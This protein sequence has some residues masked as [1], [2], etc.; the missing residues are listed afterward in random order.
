MD[1]RTLASGGTLRRILDVAVKDLV[2]YTRSMF[3]LGMMFGAPLMIAGLIYFAFSG[4]GGGEGGFQ[5]P[6][7]RVLVVN[8]DQPDS[9][10]GGFSA[11]QVLVEFLQAE[12]LANLLET[13]VANDEASAR[14]AVESQEADVA[15]IIPTD[16]SPAAFTAAGGTSVTLYQDPTL[17]IGPA[18]VKGLIENFLDGFSGSKIAAGVTAEL[19]TERG[20]Q[21]DPGATQSVVLQYADWARELGEL[22]ASRQ[23]PLIAVQPLPSKAAPTNLLADLAGKI[24]AGQLIFFSFYTA[25]A[26]AQSIITEE[27]Q[28][29]LPRLFTTPS[30]R[31]A[32]LAGKFIATFA[33][34]L[35]QAVVLTIASAFIFR[36]RWGQPLTVAMVMLG[37][38]AV[39]TGFGL[40]LMSFAK[41][42]RQAGLV[43]GAVLT[44]LG[45]AGGLFS[46]GMDVLPTAFE[47]VALLTPHGWVMRGWKLSLAGASAGEVLLPVAVVLVMGIAFFAF[48]A[49]TFRRRFA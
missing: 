9:Q 1:L 26:A 13:T 18:I 20:M 30:P 12:Q 39:S 35:G 48:G 28:K 27:E 40:F 7:T 16:L 19:F 43:M 29:T 33:L 15:V 6:V 4:L 34:V 2:R 38:V 37:L 42:T 46:A 31:T 32:I 21:A 11:G 45:M 10:Y 8:L 25:A 49:V 17:S 5:L 14:A 22:R 44:V 47:T 24:L 3:V 36:I 23:H 41:T